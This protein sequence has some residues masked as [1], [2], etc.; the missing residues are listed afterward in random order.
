[1]SLARPP[2]APSVVVE[3]LKASWV[4]ERWGLAAAVVGLL[5]VLSLPTPTGL[6]PAGQCMLAILAFAVIVWMTEAL[7]MPCQRWS[8]PP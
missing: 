7:T 3:R 5:T 4:V 8:S 6:P 2:E 1:M